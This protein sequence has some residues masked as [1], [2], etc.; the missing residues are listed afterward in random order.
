MYENNEFEEICSINQ[1][2]DKL[3]LSR[4]RFY[5]LRMSGVFPP[6]VYCLRTKRPFYPLELQKI[7]LR[8]RDTGIGQDGQMV[9]LY[10]PREKQARQKPKMTQ[11]ENLDSYKEWASILKDWGTKVTVDQVRDAVKLLFPEGLPENQDD[12]FIISSLH[13]HF[14]PEGINDV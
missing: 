5:Q 8:I 3:R 2:A 10:K 1:M 4:P 9:F 12:N 7:C 14:N 6:P 13:K 11:K